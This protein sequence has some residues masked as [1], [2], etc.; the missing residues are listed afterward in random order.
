MNLTEKLLRI[1][2]SLPLGVLYPLATVGAGVLHHI[3][4]YR[5][6]IIRKNLRDCFPDK[7]EKELRH[8]EHDFYHRFADY[9]V[10]TL[11]LMHVS[12][13][14]MRRRMQF[15]NLDIIDRHLSAGRSVAVYFSHTFNW[16]WAPAISLHSAMKP[17]DKVKFAQIYRPL[18]S[19][20]FDNI[21]LRL[22]GRFHSVSIPKA[23]TARTLLD[24]RKQGIVSVTGFMSD[25]HPGHGD[26]GTPAVLLGRPSMM[27]SGTEALARKL[28]MAVVFWD[29]RRV[30]RGHY[31]INVKEITPD[32]SA[33][34]EHSITQTYT[35]LLEENI[36]RDPSLWL[37]SHNR[38]KHPLT[39]EQ[40][41]TAYDHASI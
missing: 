28:G 18:K 16:E 14:E 27:I 2:A 36:R 38:W 8:I 15:E 23:H 7:T 33:E 11:K 10:E 9:T 26:G 34:P 41:Q 30:A 39:S 35:R 29:M 37:W 25:Q 19:K 4:R 20:K 24:W 13:S 32:A 3:V 6:G 21:M 22:R 31:I 12:D 5:R 17:S 1:P 40:I